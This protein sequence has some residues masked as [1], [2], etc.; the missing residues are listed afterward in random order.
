VL[1]D[2]SQLS[3]YKIKIAFLDLFGIETGRMNNNAV[4]GQANRLTHRKQIYVP[5][6]TLKVSSCYIIALKPIIEQKPKRNDTTLQN[7]TRIFSYA[8]YPTNKRN[9]I[10][11]WEF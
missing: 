4:R 8:A 9:N 2:L 10:D 1:C 7:R 5:A 11:P 3:K 6:K